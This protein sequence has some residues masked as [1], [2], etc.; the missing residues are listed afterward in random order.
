M[1]N[2]IVMWKF[3]PDIP[4]EERRQISAGMAAGMEALGGRLPGVHTLRVVT[5]PLESS[6]Y[7]LLLA[8]AFVSEEA[9]AAYQQNPE[10]LALKETYAPAF[11]S[12][13][14]VDYRQ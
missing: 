4:E 9:L 7:D 11:A 12:R 2:H 14:C 5:D 8:S 3:R 6:N 10:H 13:S 1:I